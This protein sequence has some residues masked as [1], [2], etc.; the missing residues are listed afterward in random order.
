M[1][2]L[3]VQQAARLAELQ[4]THRVSLRSPTVPDAPSQAA[5]VY[6]MHEAA[7]AA[8]STCPPARTFRAPGPR[9]AANTGGPPPASPAVAAELRRSPYNTFDRRAAN[10]AQRNEAAAAFLSSMRRARKLEGCCCDCGTPGMLSQNCPHR[11][12]VL[13]YFGPNSVAVKQ[14]LASRRANK[15]ACRFAH[16]AASTHGGS[17]TLAQL[18]KLLHLSVLC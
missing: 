11:S 9:G 13:Q 2:L 14:L 5:L 15:P 6:A 3:A 1:S 8:P 10:P 18:P 17:G 4:D 7:G 12:S 16:C